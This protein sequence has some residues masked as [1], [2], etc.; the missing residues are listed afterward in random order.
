MLFLDDI[1]TPE[2]RAFA[3]AWQVW[4]GADLAPRRSTVR[5]EDIPKLLPQIS[6]LEIISPERAEFRLAGTALCAAMGIELTGLNY[7]D[8]T[9]PET[10]PRRVAR[11]RRIVLHPCGA[12]VLYPIVHRS[13]R[14]VLTEVLSLPVWPNEPAA[15]LQIFA[16]SVPMEDMRLEE[17]AAEPKQLPRGEGFHF[18]DI[19]AGVPDADL[20]PTA[21]PLRS[22]NSVRTA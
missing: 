15:P 22:R 4:R 19:G 18:I 16:I 17:P 2:C 11:T 7:F 8:L 3:E 14:T 1:H 9:A 5:I 6:V 13:G 12:H 20:N 10:R 21:Q